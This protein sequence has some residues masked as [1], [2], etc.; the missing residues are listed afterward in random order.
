MEDGHDDARSA[1]A[2]GR[3]ENSDAGRT[4]DLFITGCTAVLLL[5]Q[6]LS[7]TPRLLLPAPLVRIEGA[8]VPERLAK[9]DPLD[10][11]PFRQTR[12]P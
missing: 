7:L 3:L 11:C 1:T 4:R 9:L 2:S 12:L 5:V 6:L 8:M 10:L